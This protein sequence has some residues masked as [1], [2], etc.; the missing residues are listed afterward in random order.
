M[1]GWAL[2]FLGRLWGWVFWVS[3]GELVSTVLL[4]RGYDG[5]GF[6]GILFYKDDSLRGE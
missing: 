6:L 4:G 1:E 3:V 2:V 5:V